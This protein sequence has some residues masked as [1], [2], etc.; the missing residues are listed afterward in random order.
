MTTDMGRIS[1]AQLLPVVV[2]VFPS[3]S[4]HRVCNPSPRY[5]NTRMDV[6]SS[7]QARA[8]SQH[9]GTTRKA[10]DCFV[11]VEALGWAAPTAPRRRAARTCRPWAAFGFE[12][13]CRYAVRPSTRRLSA[14]N[15]TRLPRATEPALSSSGSTLRT[16]ARRRHMLVMPIPSPSTTRDRFCSSHR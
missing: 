6:G 14:P 1:E 12:N 10:G 11:C 13:A 5:G 3:R 16:G 15:A 4:A 2:R 9:V 8:A 7:R